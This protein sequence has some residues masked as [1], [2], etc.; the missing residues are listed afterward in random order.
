MLPEDH[1]QKPPLPQRTLPCV[2][3]IVLECIPVFLMY[4][5]YLRVNLCPFSEHTSI[6]TILCME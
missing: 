4:M 3:C 2:V 6:A 5:L 1:Y